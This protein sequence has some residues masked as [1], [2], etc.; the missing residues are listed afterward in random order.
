MWTREDDRSDYYHTVSAE[1]RSRVGCFRQTNRVA[2]RGAIVHVDL[3]RAD[4]KLLSSIE[5]TGFGE[6]AICHS[7]LIEN[8]RGAGAHAYGWFRSV[9]NIPMPAA[10]SF[11]GNW[12]L[13]RARP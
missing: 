10:Q 4:P 9:N 12:L 13:L 3:R 11:I 2:A 8:P 1:R 6:R 5:L 7:Q